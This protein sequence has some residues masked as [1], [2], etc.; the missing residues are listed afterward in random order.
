[1]PPG[2]ECYKTVE[3]YSDKC[4]IP[5]KG[6]YA[7]VY[8]KEDFKQVEEIEKLRT[9]LNEYRKYKTFVNGTEGN[10]G[11]L[12]TS[13][14]NHPILQVYDRRTKLHWVR[15]YFGTPTFDRIT[16]DEK[17]NFEDKLSTIGGTMGLLTGKNKYVLHQ[18]LCTSVDTHFE[19]F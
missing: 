19:I 15:I 16:K 2:L 9:T 18:Y 10:I 11:K 6:T 13:F 14:I 5:C 1:M 17:A 3:K 7:D 8:K 12:C 4:I